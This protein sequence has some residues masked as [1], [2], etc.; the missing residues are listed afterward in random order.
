MC[1]MLLWQINADCVFFI[2]P[3][4]YV[5]DPALH[6]NS[7]PD[8]INNATRINPIPSPSV[9]L[10]T[11]F[12]APTADF[13]F[14]FVHLFISFSLYRHGCMFL[15]LSCLRIHMQE[16]EKEQQNREMLEK[17]IQAVTSLK[18]NIAATQVKPPTFLSGNALWL[19]FSQRWLTKAVEQCI[20]NTAVWALSLVQYTTISFPLW[21]FV[22]SKSTFQMWIMYFLHWRYKWCYVI[23]LGSFIGRVK[24]LGESLKS[25]PLYSYDFTHF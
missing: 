20:I 18:S 8:Y 22:W 14:S 5:D 25:C 15:S 19:L 21:G 9:L 3:I 23:A 1:L 11:S 2:A 6:C 13:F 24:I 10:L 12:K 17:R 4:F 16:A 7:F